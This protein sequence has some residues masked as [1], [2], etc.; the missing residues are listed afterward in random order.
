MSIAR[1]RNEL[2][3]ALL[4][5]LALAGGTQLASAAERYDPRLRF[6]TIRTAHFDIHAHQGEEALA[7][8]L[9]AIAERVRE[10]SRQTFGVP[11]GRVQVILVDQND[12]A[13]G[14]ATPLPYNMIEI[15]TAP[16]ALTS[17][18][19]NTIDW[20]ELVF[21]HEYTHILH[22][23]RSRGFMQGLRSVFGRVPVVFPNGFL[24]AWQI[25]GIATFQ[26]SRMTGAGR[27][28]SGD[29][30]AI[31]D[32]AAARGVFEPIDRAAGDITDWPGGHAPY[33]Y[34]AYFHQFLADR[35]GTERIA[36]LADVTAGRVP[37]FGMGGFKK[38]FGRSA[39][40]LWNEF[41]ASRAALPASRTDTNARR[42]THHG[43]TVTALRVARD[44][45]VFYGLSN[46]HG[47]PALM[48]L[49]PGEV[50]SRLA[51]RA[52]GGRTAVQGDWVVF[53]QVERVRSVALH[54]DLFAIRK[55]GGRVRRLTRGARLADPDLSPDGQRIV[56]TVQATGRRALAI[57]PFT[58]SAPAAVRTVADDPDADY[59]GPRWSPDGRRIA[60][61]RRYQG[62]FELVLVDAESGRVRV[63]LRRSDARVVTP[64][65]SPDGDSLLFSAADRS[66]PFNVFRIDVTTGAVTQL[67]DTAGGAQFPELS[68]NG[69]LTYVGYTVDGS[70]LF[71]IALGD[72][73]GSPGRFALQDED[74][75]RRQASPVDEETFRLKAEAAPEST[76]KPLRTLRPTYWTPL[77]ESDA[78]EIVIGAGTAMTDAL[79]RHAYAASAGWSNRARPDWN[80]AYAYDRWRPTVTVSYSDD[81]DPVQG[82]A[83][84]RSREL[85]AGA[86]LSFRR[87][88][89]ADT[90]LAGFDAQTDTLTCE[91]PCLVTD[92]RR[93]LR[94]VRGGWLH[95]RRRSFGYS[96]GAEEGVALQ[97]AGETSRTALGSDGDGGTAIADL[98]G[99]QRVFSRHTV[100][101]ARVAAAASYGDADARRVF[102]AAG[103]GPS[104]PV[105]DF[106]RDSIGLI[107]GI[108]PDTVVGTRALVMNVDLRVPLARPQRGAGT[109]PFFFHTIHAAAFVDAGHAW[110]RNFS[111]ADL[112]TSVGGELS[113]DL[114][115]LQYLPVTVT[116]GAAW[117]RDGERHRAAAFA[118]I[119][120][121][122]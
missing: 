33:A 61:A 52:L 53:D 9:A 81:T 16:P 2:C 87:V 82:G 112:R 50:P 70:D 28:P 59:D 49:R 65:W 62:A 46:P 17:L 10:Q 20:L 95:D 42:L 51:W 85:F 43:F 60:A 99:F 96:I 39:S 31:V 32:V 11:R 26:E 35:Y 24:P 40:D 12:L 34:G 109:W 121:A 92:G 108:D 7:R 55:E 57:V 103:A 8:R 106:G 44:G 115:I 47:F 116:G 64:S 117:T 37:F 45:T 41:R 120:Y 21:I 48:R 15:T 13:N 93:D 111:A 80:V 14:W 63:L 54:S 38:V 6:R 1:A 110:N 79:G 27:V 67:T 23:D 56:S 74:P 113:A 3:A 107:R 69:T 71:E 30:R 94:S 100:L 88:R 101:A 72:R 86:F 98:R 122:F 66:A 19:G 75:T 90:L 105:F 76:Y 97:V 36:R 25:E 73:S 84:V 22:L 77:I 58:P 4:V 119:G 114:V 68:A 102:S 5:L 89:S 18:I 118:R 78:D 29:F 91:P 104:Y 83:L